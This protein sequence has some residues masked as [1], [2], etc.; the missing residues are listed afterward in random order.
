MLLT[1]VVYVLSLT[2][3]GGNGN[4]SARGG[5]GT[6]RHRFGPAWQKHFGVWQP[7]SWLRLATPGADSSGWLLS[8]GRRGERKE[9]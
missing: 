1:Q 2:A 5:F 8:F 9:R 4:I 7:V 3:G 6:Q